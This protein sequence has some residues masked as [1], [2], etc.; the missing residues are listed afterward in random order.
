MSLSACSLLY[1][2]LGTF[3]ELRHVLRTCLY[4]F[5]NNFE[6][7]LALDSRPSSL[8][9]Y[10]FF[11]FLIS[12]TTLFRSVLYFSKRNILEVFLYFLKVRFL[13]LIRRFISVIHGFSFGLI[14]TFLLGIDSWLA[15]IMLSDIHKTL[16]SIFELFL[17][18]SYTI[19]PAGTQ[20]WLNVVC[21]LGLLARISWWNVPIWNTSHMTCFPS[22][23]YCDSP[24]KRV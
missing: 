19:H 14:V 1:I 15:C 21:L 12:F 5:Q 23:W 2:K 4:V 11:D 18:C 20:R 24:P 6:F 9:K 13:F 7:E 10:S 17:H 3:V 8:S 22:I 16:S